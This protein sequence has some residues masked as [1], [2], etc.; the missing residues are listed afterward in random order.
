M[1]ERP[2]EALF[3]A[4]QTKFGAL[5][6]QVG[7]S[8]FDA[9]RQDTTR[10]FQGLVERANANRV[11]FYTLAVPE[12][13]SGLTADT[14]GANDSWSPGLAATESI[15]Q[16]QP[17]QTL[18]GA[19]GGL[20]AIDKTGFFLDR[21]RADLDS[22]YS[23]G[24][25]PTHPQ[26]GQKHR[27]TVQVRDRTLSVRVREGYR[28][29]TGAEVTGS[30]TLSALLLGEEGNPLGVALAIDGERPHA[31]KQ[32]EVSLLV[33]LPLARL[34]LVPRGGAHEG[35]ARIFVGARDTEGRMSDI[36]EIVV[37]VHIPDDQFAAAA[38]QSIGTRVTLL[39][40]PGRHTLAVGVR[41]ELGNTDSTVTGIYTAGRLSSADGHASPPGGT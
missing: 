14:A 24:Y 32:Y 17:L 11:T 20:A 15:N 16:T 38:S 29:R 35:R 33:K 28:E 13:L 6:S 5:S 10:L 25:V 21:L 23:L 37:P 18:A 41:D 36:Q 3:E 4:W 7:A 39:L 31:K 22:Y 40:R 34:V 30:R 27:L 12:D 1:S 26:A 8:R 19:T 2:G 9:F